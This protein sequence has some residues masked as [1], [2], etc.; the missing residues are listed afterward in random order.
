MANNKKIK[1]EDNSR[2]IPFRMIFKIL[3]V[4]VV[5]F[6]LGTINLVLIDYYQATRPQEPEVIPQV[7]NQD[8]YNIVYLD[9]NLFYFCLIEDFNPDYLKCNEPFYLVR[10]REDNPETGEQTEQVFV[11]SPEEEEIYSPDGA[12]YLNKD[13]IVYIAK[14]G[15]SSPVLEYINSLP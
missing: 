4:L 6:T 3:V 10:K 15:E 12:I 14:I 7:Y 1:T 11:K 8:E 13:K 2:S 9:N 5:L